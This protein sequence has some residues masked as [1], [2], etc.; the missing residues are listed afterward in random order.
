[1]KR[2]HVVFIAFSFCLAG[3]LA[4]DYLKEFKSPLC[5]YSASDSIT[6]LVNENYFNITLSEIKNARSSIS[7]VLY[8]FKW[9]ESNNTVIQLRNALI[10]SAKKNVSIRMILDQSQ[11][12]G[13]VTELSKENKK[14]GDYLAENGIQ[15]KYDSMKI[16]THDKMLII[17]GKTVILGSHNWGSSALTKN[18]EASVMIKDQEI[19]EY[20]GAYFENLWASY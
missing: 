7:I 14:T 6:P 17:D 12:M 10:D 3:F 20:Y 2:W 9:Y 1:M 13:Q 8:E 19:A 15:V 18:N 4:A 16:T 11:W 5:S